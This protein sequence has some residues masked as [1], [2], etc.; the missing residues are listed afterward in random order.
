MKKGILLTKHIYSHYILNKWPPY[1]IIHKFSK[2]VCLLFK[3]CLHSDCMTASSPHNII[4]IHMLMKLRVHKIYG[5]ILNLLKYV[6]CFSGRLMH[7]KLVLGHYHSLLIFLIFWR[8]HPNL[9]KALAWKEE[10]THKYCTFLQSHAHYSVYLTAL[11]SNVL[12][13][14]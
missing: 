8:H 5:K 11:W 1:R 6:V 13:S 12:E 10:P 3:D 7:P 2:S 4:I 9:R 14:Y